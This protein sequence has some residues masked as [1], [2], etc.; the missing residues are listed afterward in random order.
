[1]PRR[2]ETPPEMTTLRVKRRTA[3]IVSMISKARHKTAEDI[4]MDMLEQLYA[5][6]IRMYDE[7]FGE[8][9]DDKPEA[10]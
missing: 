7:L 2:A 5:K 1:M 9:D 4:V 3:N 6:E 8:I 10:K